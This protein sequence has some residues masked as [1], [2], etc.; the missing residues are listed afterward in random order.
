METLI[1]C[2]LLFFFL[3]SLLYLIKKMMSKEIRNGVNDE[4]KT[5][6]D[7]ITESITPSKES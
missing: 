2:L 7:D 3:P 6:I 4:L 5:M 1:T